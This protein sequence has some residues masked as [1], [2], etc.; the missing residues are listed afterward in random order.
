[1]KKIVNPKFK[2]LRILLLKLGR[3]MLERVCKNN[4]L[5]FIR[6][7]LYEW[8][9]GVCILFC[10]QNTYMSQYKVSKSLAHSVN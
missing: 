6:I 10:F 3:Q 9:F 5:H 2:I 8:V 1:M 4:S 7:G